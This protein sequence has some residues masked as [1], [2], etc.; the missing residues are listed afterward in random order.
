MPK[1]TGSNA[2]RDAQTEAHARA[3]SGT[4]HSDSKAVIALAVLG[5]VYGDIGTSPIYA[6]RECFFGHNPVAV[7]PQNVLG[8]LSLMFWTLMLADP[9]NSSHHFFYLAPSWGL[10]PLILQATAATCIASQAV[11]TGA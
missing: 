1:S 9:A 4:P 6:L 7:S 3:V 11:T 2:G 5:I 10:V 8:I